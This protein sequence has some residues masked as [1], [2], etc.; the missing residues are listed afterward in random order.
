MAATSSLDSA[1]HQHLQTLKAQVTQT[2]WSMPAPGPV[3]QPGQAQG[4]SLQPQQ[5]LVG[6]PSTVVQPTGAAGAS[7]GPGVLSIVVDNLPFRYQLSEPDLREMFQR[8]GQLQSVQVN[9]D[10]ARE[11]GVISFGNQIDASVAQQDFHGQ[12]VT[13]E[14][15]MGTLVVLH[16]GPEQLSPPMPRS[17]PFMQGPTM[18]QGMGATAPQGVVHPTAGQCHV[19]SAGQLPTGPALGPQPMGMPIGAPPQLPSGIAGAPTPNMAPGNLMPMG[20]PPPMQGMPMTSPAQM[21]PM[22]GMPPQAISQSLHQGTMPSGSLAPG[23][24]GAMPK[25]APTQLS[26]G[27]GKGA[28][29]NWQPSSMNGCDAAGQVRWTCKVVVQADTFHP[30]FP[31]ALKIVGPNGANVDH[32]RQQHGCDVQLRGRSSMTLEPDTGQEM[33]E[34]MFLWLTAEDQS[35]SMTV[36]EMVKDLLKSVY[37]EYTNWCR[38]H[39]LSPGPFMEPLIMENADASAGMS[40]PPSGMEWGQ[41]CPGKVRPF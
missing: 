16:G 7:V 5:P 23:P 24:S 37:D 41:G 31:Y 30:D 26:D 28:G 39:N 13:V 22:P 21:A 29:N 34:P 25:S 35:K 10:G 2:S 27:M 12:V 18:P 11:V 36:V 1:L 40:L 8:W 9:R 32:I 33:Q 17:V 20:G 15:A 19:P 14:G 3:Q 6:A 4:V 38:A